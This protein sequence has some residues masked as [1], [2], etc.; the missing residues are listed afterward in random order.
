MNYVQRNDENISFK[1]VLVSGLI[2]VSFIVTS[3]SSSC[4]PC[5]SCGVFSVLFVHFSFSD[6][7]SWAASNFSFDLN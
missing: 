2:V 3:S 5:F 6:C 7:F 1:S 4:I